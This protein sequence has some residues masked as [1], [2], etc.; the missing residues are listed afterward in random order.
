MRHMSK[1][2]KEKGLVG[3]LF[4]QVVPEWYIAAS[5]NDFLDNRSQV[6]PTQTILP[7]A[8]FLNGYTFIE[9]E[10]RVTVEKS[11]DIFALKDLTAVLKEENPVCPLRIW[12]ETRTQLT[13]G[14]VLYKALLGYD[15]KKD[16][17]MLGVYET[18]GPPAPE[19]KDSEFALNPE[20]A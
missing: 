3:K 5:I 17:I 15:L 18:R 4:A 13:D 10:S 8:C 19:S 7:I 14:M 6:Q 11:G 2:W 12:K 20:P 1:Y 9:L 16:E